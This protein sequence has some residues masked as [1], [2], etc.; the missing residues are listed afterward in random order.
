MLAFPAWFV[1]F[2]AIFDFEARRSPTFKEAVRELHE[3][4]AARGI[5]GDSIHIGWPVSGQVG[6]EGTTGRTVLVMAVDGN[7]GSGWM[8][9]V[10]TKI[11]GVWKTEQLVI[12]SL[13]GK[14]H[15]DIL[16]TPSSAQ[17]VSP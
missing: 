6:C 11:D 8:R 3:S 15:E 2:G 5:F 7:R 17:H 12:T 10:A 16:T 1:P 13:D 9:A 14:I 4:E